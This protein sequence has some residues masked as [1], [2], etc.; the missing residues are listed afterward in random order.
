MDHQSNEKQDHDLAKAVSTQEGPFTV[1]L[2]L[3]SDVDNNCS[4]VRHGILVVKVV[5][6]K[7]IVKEKTS[8]I[9]TDQRTSLMQTGAVGGAEG[10]ILTEDEESLVWT[11]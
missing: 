10:W 8:S 11:M 1:I 4:S 2:T 6:I 3:Q 7:L 5:P 9:Q